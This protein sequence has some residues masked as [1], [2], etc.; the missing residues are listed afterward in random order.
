MSVTLLVCAYA[1]AAALLLNVWVATRWPTVVKIVLVVLVTLLYVGSYLG[2]RD[3]QGWPSAEPLPDTFRLLWAKIEEP[4]KAAGSEG[5]IYL[6][7]RKLDAAQRAVGEPRAYRL[8]WSL[9]LAEKVA[10]ALRRTEAGEPLNGS[11]TRQPIKEAGEE[12]ED[13]S[14]VTG[15]DEGPLQ[16][17][18]S[19]LPRTLLPA[20]GS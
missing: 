15:L 1:V 11:A 2:L 6:W 5:Q 3:I 18:F 13:D 7:V 9:P 10:E 14:V 4:D 19:A 8:A 20:K 16:L 17:E 12:K